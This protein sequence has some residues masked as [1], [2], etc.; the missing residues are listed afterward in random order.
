MEYFKK[1]FNEIMETV[2]EGVG[3]KK[4]QSY[5]KKYRNRDIAIFLLFMTTGMRREEMREINIEDI[6]LLERKLSIV[7]KGNRRRFLS[8][9]DTVLQYVCAWLED[10][11]EL[12]FNECEALFVNRYGKRMTGQ[13]IYDLIDLDK[14][15]KSITSSYFIINLRIIIQIVFYSFLSLTPPSFLSTS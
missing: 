14:S 15:I 11:K 4:A 5:Q 8:I 6:N 1:Y 3:S 13:A 2:M 12:G 9:T 10:R 7:I